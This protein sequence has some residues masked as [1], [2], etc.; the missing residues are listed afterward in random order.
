MVVTN[1]SISSAPVWEQPECVGSNRLQARATFYHYPG[2]AVA[3]G[4]RREQ[5]PWFMLLNGRWRFRLVPNPN[6]DD[7]PFIDPAANDEAGWSQIEVPGCWT[8]QGFDKPIYTNVQ[9]PFDTIP[10][11]V[12]RDDN[13]TGWYRQRFRVPTDW[14]GRRTVLHFGGV[15]GCYFAYVNGHL[16]GMAKDARLPAEYDVSPWVHDGENVL[17]VKVIR[18]SDASFI[19]DQDQWWQAGIHREVYLYMTPDLHLDDIFAKPD[20]GTDYR[21]GSLTVNV[22]LSDSAAT[23]E[24]W[25]VRVRLV[26]PRGRDV[27]MDPM[28]AKVGKGDW[29]CGC[30]TELTLSREAGEVETWSAEEPVLY[31]VLVSL[32]DPS[33]ALV[34]CTTVRVGFR[35]IEVR[36]R[37]V[38]VN[39]RR[40]MFHGVNRHDHHPEKGRAVPRETMVADVKLMK[41]FNVNA[42]RTSHYPNDPYWL[43]LCDEYGMYVIDEANIECH[44]CQP[45]DI[46]ARDERW[47]PAFVDRGSRMVLRDKHHPSVIFWSLGNESGFGPNHDAMA[48]WIRRYDP[49]RPIHYSEATSRRWRDYRPVKGQAH[50]HCPAPEPGVN[51]LATDVVSPMYPHIAWIKE[52]AETQD[53]ERRPLIMCEYSHAMGNSNGCLKEYWD[54]IESHHG[55]QGGFIWEWIDH[56]IT[57]TDKNGVK[58]WA[59]GGDF[60][61]RKHDANFCCDGLVWPDRTPHPAMW[62][63][64]WCY[65]PAR[66]TRAPGANKLAIAIQNRQD[67]LDLSH[68]GGYWRITVDGR[69]VKRGRLP[70]LRTPPGKSQ[71]VTLPVKIVEVERG[72]EAFLDVWFVLDH[73]SSWCTKGHEVARD[74][75]PLDRKLLKPA[76]E[77]IRVNPRTAGPVEIG[78]DG[79]GWEV[80]QGDMSFV[81]NGAEGRISG[82]E[83]G[84]RSVMRQ[85]PSINL[86]RAATDNDGL[87]LWTGQGNKALGK[88]QAIGLP[89]ATHN[90]IRA[91]EPRRERDGS[92]LFAS[93]C[94]VIGHDGAGASHPIAVCAEA[95]KLTPGG[96]LVFDATVKLAEGVAD[97]P[98]LGVTMVLAP[99]MELVA[100]LGRGPHENYPDRNAS[101]TVAVYRGTVKEQ[102]VPY[103]MP[104]ENGLKTDVRW[105]TLEDGKTGLLVA[106]MPLV[107]FSA[108]HY[109]DADLFAAKHTN[110]LKVRQEVFL[111]L[112][113]FHRGLGT[114]SC[115]PD[116]LPEYQMNGGTH[117]FAF[118]MRPFRTGLDV[119]SRM[120]RE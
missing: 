84:G 37:A 116:T 78:K 109:S 17:A 112:D 97:L 73:A 63:V 53:E 15:E 3:L 99:L 23:T 2:E 48:A 92:V 55:L 79:S 50:P 104:Q 26:D 115:G 75:I 46:L 31:L 16:V 62:E 14:V 98:R 96:W 40:V 59:Y 68:F 7:R 18:W 82:L 21:T 28:E 119:P 27:W 106:G 47:A 93:E 86:W 85:G 49:S 43:D 95:V 42:V 6:H 9:M 52:W 44:A 5:D 25:S 81:W 83:L 36:D 54:A 117:K 100:W 87:K 90:V 1:E 51:P 24:G 89:A 66:V 20:L 64:K 65:Q 8:M 58:Y 110:E 12:P 80:R 38:L 111:N 19:E 113:G 39:G 101:A 11:H 105:L 114:R 32:V 88:W 69:E 67:F 70:P 30:H 91:D 35:R 103:I 4:G 60:G 13:P 74:Q 56:G 10:P 57:Q 72:Q 41:R 33:G 118:R 77:K 108:K 76:K 61:E 102:H 94:E 107:A 71:V 120:A 45:G 22:R 29:H 34:E